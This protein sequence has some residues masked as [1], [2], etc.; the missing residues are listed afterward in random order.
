MGDD[1]LRAARMDMYHAAWIDMMSM[2]MWKVWRAPD[3]EAK[4]KGA[5]QFWVEFAKFLKKHDSLLGKTNGPFYSGSLVRRCH[6]KS[7]I[8]QVANLSVAFPSRHFCLHVD[9]PVH[10]EVAPIP[11]RVDH[12]GELSSFVGS[13]EGSWGTGGNQELFGKWQVEVTLIKCQK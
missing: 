5:S 8:G 1:P 12:G 3:D 7:V 2:F 13:M 11:G 6:L 4:R 10:H 9:Q